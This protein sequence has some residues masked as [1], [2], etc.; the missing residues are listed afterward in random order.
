MVYAGLGDNDR[1]FQW[2]DRAVEER[3]VNLVHQYELLR[4][5]RSDPRYDR[6]RARLGIQKR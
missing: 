6:F 1:A 2:I 4:G 5:L 3:S